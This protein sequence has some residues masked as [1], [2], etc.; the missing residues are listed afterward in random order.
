MEDIIQ[1]D[2]LTKIY[3]QHTLKQGLK[4]L[5]SSIKT[6]ET[7]SVHAVD[8]IS[9][10]IKQGE[11]IGYIGP[12]GAGKSTTIKMLSGIL[13]PTSGKI[14]IDG[15]VPW[16][17]RKQFAYKIG[18]V[19][20]QR[21]QLWWD[22]PIIDTYNLYGHMYKISKND[23]N[24]RVNMLTKLLGL[25]EFWT[26]PV[27][28]LSLGQRMRGELGAALLH[29]PK[30]LFLDEPTIGMDVIVK[31]SIRN[32]IKEI[33][34]K[35]GTTVILTTHDMDDVE[36]ICS[37]IAV[38]NKGKLIYD[39][40]MDMAKKRCKAMT[41]LEVEFDCDTTK[42]DFSKLNVVNRNKNKIQF[43]FIRNDIGVGKILEQLSNYA[44][45]DIKIIEPPIEEV[46]RD[47]YM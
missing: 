13:V 5:F 39:G 14:M 4:G 15:L 7:E 18:V 3:K 40:T 17:S 20:G 2:N 24:E 34:E 44:I 10:K 29:R 28:Q 42:C 31:E 21:S 47:L 46:I 30:I 26:R 11:L 6:A 45:R 22:L 1:V 32:F 9:F 35:E 8:N 36:Q 43:G 41:I 16:K 38:I 27:R 23:F 37:R 25:D 33:N 19:F 12:N